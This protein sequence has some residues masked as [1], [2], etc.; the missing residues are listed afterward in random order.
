MQ[1]LRQSYAGVVKMGP[2]V[3]P[4]TGLP[5][6][7]A[8]IDQADVQLSKNQGAFAQK[9]EATSNAAHTAGGIFN[10]TL[11]ATDTG[12]LGS[13]RVMINLSAD[14][15][16]PMVVVED[17]MILDPIV[18]DMWF[19]ANQFRDMLGITVVK[20]TMASPG[21]HSTTQ[22]SFAAADGAKCKV[23]Y[24][25]WV[26]ATYD[27]HRVK[28]LATDAWTVDSGDAFSTDPF[29]AVYYII[30]NPLNLPLTS[31]DLATSFGQAIADRFLARN[32]QGGADSA[33]TVATTIASGLMS[34]SISG[35]T[36][37]VKYGDGTTAFTR[38]LTRSQL[39][40][41]ISSL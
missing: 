38:T 31:S 4:A 11:D 30:A 35:A 39:D 2:F 24:L 37:T 19:V 7:G 16:T 27:L 12:T 25:I 10:I 36:M 3:D 17:Y 9:N 14:A 1:F 6:T 32:S 23:G 18:Y 8:D 20:G 28:T 26:P 40:A 33:P 22:G 34:F 13:L 15:N 41:I 5:V 21:G 29:G